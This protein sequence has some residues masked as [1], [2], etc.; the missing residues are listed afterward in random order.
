MV[1]VL[2]S[3]LTP[4]QSIRA[5]SGSGSGGSNFPFLIGSVQGN[6]EY[7]SSVAE[8]MRFSLVVSNSYDKSNSENCP[9]LEYD[10]DTSK[11]LAEHIAFL[12]QSFGVE[13]DPALYRLEVRP[14]RT[15]LFEKD[16]SDDSETLKEF[17]DLGLV[18]VV[19]LAR[20]LAETMSNAC[21]QAP[22]RIEP[23]SS[24]ATS[25]K[26][27]LLNLVKKINVDLFTEEFISEGGI[28]TLLMITQK[29][30]GNLAAYAIKALTHT[31]RYLNGLEYMK[32]DQVLLQQLY[33]LSYDMR[34]VNV[35][36]Q[37]LN[38]LLIVIEY[39]PNGGNAVI[40][41][42]VKASTSRNIP[43]FE[44]LCQLLKTGDLHSQIVSLAFMNAAL[45]SQKEM[46]SRLKLIQL[47]TDCG[48]F[49]YL[50]TKVDTKNEEFMDQIDILY[51]LTNAIVPSTFF[52]TQHFN[53]K[54]EKLENMNAQHQSTI[55]EYE[56]KLQY[57]SILRNELVRYKAIVSK[58]FDYN[59]LISPEE[60]AFRASLSQNLVL[61]ELD[62]LITYEKDHK[63]L[64]KEID[65]LNNEKQS[66]ILKLNACRENVN[67]LKEQAKD[68]DSLRKKLAEISREKKKMEIKQQNQLKKL[69]R[70]RLL[71]EAA[72]LQVMKLKRE[73]ENAQ[74]LIHSQK[75][76]AAISIPKSLSS[77]FVLPSDTTVE[78]F[79]HTQQTKIAHVKSQ[80]P[81]GPTSR[82]FWNSLN[83]PLIFSEEISA[84][85]STNG[86]HEN[87]W[88][89][90]TN[91]EVDFCELENL[92][93]IEP[94]QEPS[95]ERRS[96]V[97]GA[98]IRGTVRSCVSAK[99]LTAAGYL[100]TKL[101]SSEIVKKAIFDLD[102]N[103]LSSEMVEHILNFLPSF[104]EMC[105]L[106]QRSVFGKLDKAEEFIF[107][108]GSIPGISYR[109]QCWLFTLQLADKISTIMNDIITISKAC[110][111]IRQC[112]EPVK[113]LHI[114]LEIGNFLNGGAQ[115]IRVNA[116]SLSIL[117]YLDD[118]KANDRVMT[119]GKYISRLCR[120][121]LVDI[122]N[123]NS[124]LEILN[125]VSNC[126]SL[127][128]L[129]VEVKKIVQEYE[130]K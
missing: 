41:A 115:Q 23:A 62:E 52:S 74:Q 37:V 51:S 118:F 70:E 19:E 27:S 46:D 25:L 82:F 110:E 67:F 24:T 102:E 95:P 56:E 128:D 85:V 21:K 31:M 88:N 66:L 28:V 59:L 33:D 65:K 10:L 91:I 72:E 125:S 54:L 30:D 83:V 20:Y 116:F 60:P 96:T 122:S 34:R 42:A 4:L 40:E 64:L 57:L 89:I 106:H 14:L 130:R 68:T 97:R 53:R 36:R 129:R 6:N 86:M 16:I 29:S 35:C 124:E 119:V 43:P 107:S 55:K 105:A 8:A 93:R 111:K 38:L 120:R 114:I 104:S 99:R 92:F 15:C 77:S 18:N 9:I 100:L 87:A 79:N 32:N 58:A 11:S 61:E 5:G 112:K 12:C 71:S 73:L 81:T 127:F 45:K 98:M 44:N 63:T 75:L 13:E 103:V 7:G 2:I 17:V 49:N 80:L 22:G 117:N 69:E 126:K 84:S 26:F 121:N 109:L 108:V 1:R 76:P 3:L 48:I 113:V 94:E 78:F 123:L 47:F 39:M 50:D 90:L 101:P